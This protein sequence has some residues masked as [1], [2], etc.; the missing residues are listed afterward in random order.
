MERVVGIDVSKARLDVHVLPDKQAF[1][2]ART[3]NGIDELQSKLAAL[4]P[5]LAEVNDQMD[6]AVRS[7][8]GGA[9]KAALLQT[10]PGIGLVVSRTLLAEL[11]ELGTLDRRKIASLVGLAPWTR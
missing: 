1:A 7:S 4:A 3:P 2:V 8:P 5:Q 11:P 6:D 10:V 9:E